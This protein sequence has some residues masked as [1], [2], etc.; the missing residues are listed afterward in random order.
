MKERQE[1]KEVPVSMVYAGYFSEVF[2]FGTVFLHILDPGI[3]K[4]L[5]RHRSFIPSYNQSLFLKINML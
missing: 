5:R 2:W 3:P 1:K 4:N